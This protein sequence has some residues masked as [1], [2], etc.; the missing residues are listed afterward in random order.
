[1]CTMLNHT[2]NQTVCGA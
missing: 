1:M 2:I